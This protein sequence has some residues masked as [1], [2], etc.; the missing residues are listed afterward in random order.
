MSAPTAVS[1]TSPEHRGAAVADTNQ[2]LSNVTGIDPPSDIESDG[3]EDLGTDRV[4][5]SSSS[6]EE[7][8]LKTL[9]R[10]SGSQFSPDNPC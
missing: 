2:G 3:A 10:V 8:W 5:S 4:P 7:D 6:L 9:T 1:H